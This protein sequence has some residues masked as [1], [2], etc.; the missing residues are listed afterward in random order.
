MDESGLR[1]DAELNRQRLLAAARELFASEGTDV[2]MR[3]IARR[4]GV[5]EP[6]LRRRFPSKGALLA[7]AF[8]DRIAAYADLAEAALADPDPWHGFVTF[9][10]QIAGMQ[11]VDRGFTEVLTMSFP[12]SIRFA[13][14]RRRGYR[15]IQRVIARAQEIGRLRDDFVPEDLVMLLLAHAGVV[16]GGGDQ[17][18][19]F[20]ARL[21]A[22]LLQA[23]K[24]TA[25]TEPLPPAPS[26]AEAYGELLRLSATTDRRRK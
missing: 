9:V 16:A 5:G 7:E 13:A 11:L 12:A 21:L 18:G 3:H 22:Y 19:R 20:S 26:E 4:A 14:E 25:E 2:S 8:Q 23:A 24:A 1:A 17:A 6:T 15:A 10:E